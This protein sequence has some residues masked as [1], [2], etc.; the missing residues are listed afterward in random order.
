VP[1][2]A[3][4]FPFAFPDPERPQDLGTCRVVAKRRS[5]KHSATKSVSLRPSHVLPSDAAVFGSSG[6]ATDPE[7]RKEI[8]ALT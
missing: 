6:D 5:V 2:S 4:G 3:S 1:G 8:R 7:T